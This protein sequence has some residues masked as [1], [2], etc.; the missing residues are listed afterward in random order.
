MIT[1]IFRKVSNGVKSFISINFVLVIENGDPAYGHNDTS[2]L[3]P[4]F[5][6]SQICVY[7]LLVYMSFDLFSAV[8]SPRVVIYSFATLLS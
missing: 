6:P 2:K 4:H 8:L 5:P 1:L 3:R 7:G